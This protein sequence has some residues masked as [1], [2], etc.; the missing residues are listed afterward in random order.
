MKT[1]LQQSATFE[2]ASAEPE[3]NGESHPLERPRR[4][5]G[6]IGRLA[7]AAAITVIAYVVLIRP[8]HLRWGSTGEEVESPL[9]GDELVKGAKLSATHAITID[10]AVDRVWPWLVQ[11][12]QWRG[13]HY[14]YHWLENIVGCDIHSADAIIPEFQNLQPGDTFRLGPE[15]YPRFIVDSIDPGRSIVLWGGEGAP[16]ALPDRNAASWAFVLHPLGKGGTRLLIRFRSDWEPGIGASMFNRGVLEP[17]HFIMER[18]MIYGIKNR[19][20]KLP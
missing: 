17:A 18:K 2:F 20:E 9:P 13:G 8:W 4:L 3:G 11:M 10:A 6:I 5:R 16:P 19:A 14:S 15:G 7:G 12:G 1:T